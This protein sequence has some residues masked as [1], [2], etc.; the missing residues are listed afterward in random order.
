MEGK[1]LNYAT[2]A[3]RNRLKGKDVSDLRKG[4]TRT[5]ADCTLSQK[6]LIAPSC[7]IRFLSFLD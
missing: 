6:K 3:G 1:K 5:R 7:D 2:Q 4:P